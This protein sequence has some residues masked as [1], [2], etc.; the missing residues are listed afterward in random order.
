M[1]AFAAQHPTA[2]NYLNLTISLYKYK[3][4]NECVDACEKA[5]KLDPLSAMAY[6]NMCGCYNAQGEWAKAEEACKKS[7]QI[8]STLQ[9]AKKNLIMA[10][11][12]LGIVK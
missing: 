3:M 1:T 4:Y 11:K 9:L 10:Q 5:L 6:N 7:L 2:N 8:D 12:H